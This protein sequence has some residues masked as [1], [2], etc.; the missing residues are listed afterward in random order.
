MVRRKKRSGEG[1]GRSGGYG[2]ASQPTYP[3]T[4]QSWSKADFKCSSEPDDELSARNPSVIRF[5][6]YNM[7]KR[8]ALL[9][10]HA[11][12]SDPHSFVSG[13]QVRNYG[14]LGDEPTLYLRL[15]RSVRSASKLARKL[16]VDYGSSTLRFSNSGDDGI[17]YLAQVG[18][19]KGPNIDTA[20]RELSDRLQSL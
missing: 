18:L 5:V 14:H 6:V 10:L 13:A 3:S 12:I 8:E 11:G 20:R 4:S 16:E 9:L 19:G 2:N 15:S 7:D 17:S 1:G